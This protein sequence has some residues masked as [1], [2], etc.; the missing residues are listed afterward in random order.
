MK[1]LILFCLLL[2]SA[3]NRSDFDDVFRL[4]YTVRP[5]PDGSISLQSSVTTNIKV[6][7][8]VLLNSKGDVYHDFLDGDKR[9]QGFDGGNT[10]DFFVEFGSI[11]SNIPLDVYILSAQDK[12]GEMYSRV[13]GQ[14]YVVEVGGTVD[15]G[16]FSLNLNPDANELKVLSDG[17]V[18][19]AVQIVNLQGQVVTSASSGTFITNDYVASF[20]VIK[21]PLQ[22]NNYTF[23]V[24]GTIIRSTDSNIDFGNINI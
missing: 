2:C 3:C 13:V 9:N 21:H 23:E 24:S 14:K 4:E 10:G 5:N 8:Y 17:T 12:N 6:A 19:G 11:L 20:Q 7:E 1:K 16:T 15:D 18:S 22:N